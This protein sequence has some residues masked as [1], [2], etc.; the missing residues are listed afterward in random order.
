MRP[1]ALA[2]AAALGLAG[3]GLPPP[4][5]A[6]QKCMAKGG[7]CSTSTDA[8]GRTTRLCGFPMDDKGNISL[9]K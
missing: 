8:A 3:C 7:V 5:D 1:T 6:C 9:P 4:D 2:L